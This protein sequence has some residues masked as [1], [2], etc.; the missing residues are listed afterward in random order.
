[1]SQVSK[2]PK[3]P[4]AVHA[5][6]RPKVRPEDAPIDFVSIISVMFGTGAM[7]YEVCARALFIFGFLNTFAVI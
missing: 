5:Y 3:D 2:S 1:M 7:F 6:V 4:T